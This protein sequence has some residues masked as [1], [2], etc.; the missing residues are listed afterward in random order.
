M[1]DGDERDTVYI[2][3]VGGL[4]FHRYILFGL[5]DPVAYG[6]LGEE[7]T[8][9]MHSKLGIASQVLMRLS[10]GVLFDESEDYMVIFNDF[11]SENTQ[12]I[13]QFCLS[14]SVCIQSNLPISI[15]QT[16]HSFFVLSQSGD[17]VRGAKSE[18][19][20]IPKTVLNNSVS[21]L[22]ESFQPL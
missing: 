15:I 5:L 7:P 17:L 16:N 13:I 11:I 8:D 4:F 12:T 3:C 21:I 2:Q 9:R 1:R 14:L 20:T 18:N 6:I 10:Y 22:T 19:A